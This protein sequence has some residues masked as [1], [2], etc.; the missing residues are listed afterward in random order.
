M[1]EIQNFVD[2]LQYQKRYSLLTCKSY[3][4]DLL[5]MAD[6]LINL[7]VENLLDVG[8]IKVLA[9]KARVASIC[10]DK[11]YI[12]ITMAKTHN[13]TAK[14]LMVLPQ[15]FKRRIFF[16]ATDNLEI[17]LEPGNDRNNSA[18]KLTE[19]LLGRISQTL[20]N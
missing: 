6:F 3:Q 1:E 2:Y 18:L 17:F 15:E 16:N 7:G 19:R 9:K 12:K 13:L 11:Q 5:Q 14:E 20:D 10:E 8:K 4:A